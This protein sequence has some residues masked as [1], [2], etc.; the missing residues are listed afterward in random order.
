MSDMLASTIRE[1]RKEAEEFH[2]RAYELDEAADLLSRIHEERALRE[3]KVTD[4]R[5]RVKEWVKPERGQG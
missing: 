3:N 2:A 1:L 4:L 5:K